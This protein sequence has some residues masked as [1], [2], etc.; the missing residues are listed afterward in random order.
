MSFQCSI[1]T[2]FFAQKGGLDIHIARV[3]EGVKNFE[4]GICG[5]L[6]YAK[7]EMNN[8]IQSIHMIKNTFK[9]NT[10]GKY[11][12]E[13]DLDTHMAGHES[14]HEEKKEVLPYVL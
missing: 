11:F 2:S 10:C 4:C 8:H 9:C 14:V 6:F 12:P 3:H 1:C 5:H 7:N 13:G